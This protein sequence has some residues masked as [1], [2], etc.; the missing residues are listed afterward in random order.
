M[1]DRSKVPLTNNINMLNNIM[2]QTE[3]E[4]MKNGGSIKSKPKKK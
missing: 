4:K 1:K 3:N 2:K